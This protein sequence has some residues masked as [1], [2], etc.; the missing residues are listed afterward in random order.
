M[1]SWNHL[2]LGSRLSWK[3]RCQ[4]L[5]P[6]L[7]E[8]L[9]G[10]QQNLSEHSCSLY[11]LIQIAQYSTTE[12]GPV[13]SGHC[14]IIERNAQYRLKDT[15]KCQEKLLKSAASHS[16]LSETTDCF[17]HRIILH[18]MFR[19]CRWTLFTRQAAAW[20]F[21]RLEISAAQHHLLRGSQEVTQ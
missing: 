15:T 10:N 5:P 8:R 18:F 17:S 7:C 6:Q 14:K 21:P 9:Q 1:K 19:Q 16:P 11:T 3:T 13:E 20:L 4:L 2:S 12:H